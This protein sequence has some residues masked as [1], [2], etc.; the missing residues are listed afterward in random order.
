[1]SGESLRDAV[2]RE[3]N[4]TLLSELCA[5]VGVEG[6][7]DVELYLE[8]I[9]AG[10]RFP[11]GAALD[12]RLWVELNALDARGEVVYSSGV[13]SPESPASEIALSDPLMWLMRDRAFDLQAQ[14]THHFW[15]VDAVERAT[16]PPSR[17]EGT[18]G[19][20]PHVLH[21]YR[22]GSPTPIRE[23]QVTI[24]LRP[25]ALEVLY[26]LQDAGLLSRD[27]IDQMPQYELR[28]ARQIWRVEEAI[29]LATRSG[30]MLLCTP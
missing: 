14:E 20:E 19:E 7:A 8:N 5:E 3:L 10:H 21:R 9:S 4:L 11:S 24:Y 30:R 1:M 6:G 29:P 17:L 12:R 26:E 16:L 23:I 27:V 22:F 28:D 2:E 18:E 13:V 25:I 15:E